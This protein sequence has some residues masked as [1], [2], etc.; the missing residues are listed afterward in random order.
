MN[1]QSNTT[2]TSNFL[3]S[4]W[5]WTRSITNRPLTLYRWKNLRKVNKFASPIALLSWREEHK[6]GRLKTK[7]RNFPTILNLSSSCQIWLALKMLFGPERGIA[8]RQSCSM[9]SCYWRFFSCFPAA[10]KGQGVKHRAPICL[11]Q[12]GGAE[13]MS[14]IVP[15]SNVL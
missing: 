5:Q 9:Q 13:K 1:R 15:Y 6:R 8:R 14:S 11:G 12:V 4:V 7:L 2:Y 3:P 10:W